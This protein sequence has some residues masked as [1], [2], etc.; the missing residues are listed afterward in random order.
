MEGHLDVGSSKIS[1]LIIINTINIKATTHIN[2]PK[3]DA[4][5][6]GAVENPIIPS[7]E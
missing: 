1:V 4:S 5:A 3:N 2:I 6:N 7:K